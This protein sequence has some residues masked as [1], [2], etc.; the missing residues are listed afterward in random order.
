MT[1][2]LPVRR[3][4]DFLPLLSAAMAGLGRDGA[5]AFRD[6]FT[7]QIRNANTRGAYARAVASFCAWLDER[8]VE[9]RDVQAVQ[10]AA[11]HR[12]DGHARREGLRQGLR[13]ADDQAAP[14]SDP[15]ALR[16]P[17][18]ASGASDQPGARRAR[19]LAQATKSCSAA[20][21]SW[22]AAARGSLGT[23][24]SVSWAPQSDA[25]RFNARESINRVCIE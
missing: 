4:G 24:G 14:R 25:G 6:Y 13:D 17:S 9:L 8:G 23:G 19:A 5:K 20:A 11:L 7:G 18:R 21:E 12:V 10:I 16:V 15:N 3:E 2:H 22:G 1:D